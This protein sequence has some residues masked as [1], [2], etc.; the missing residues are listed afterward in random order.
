[1]PKAVITHGSHFY[2]GGVTYCSTRHSCHS[3]LH[4][5]RDAIVSVAILAI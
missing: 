2:Q 3:G 1:M 5:S 4:G